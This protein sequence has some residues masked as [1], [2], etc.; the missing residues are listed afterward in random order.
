MQCFHYFYMASTL[1]GM[2]DLNVSPIDIQ[3]KSS[4]VSHVFFYLESSS[5]WMLV[6]LITLVQQI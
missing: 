3:E 2:F 6:L 4:D 1:L 5:Q